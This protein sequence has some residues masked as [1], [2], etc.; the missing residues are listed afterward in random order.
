[1]QKEITIMLKVPISESDNK[2]ET[3]LK[4][5]SSCLHSAL[6]DNEICTKNNET[7]SNLSYKT[8][9]LR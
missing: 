3:Y 9:S 7:V 4:V 1:M 6:I 2:M 8:F 5:W